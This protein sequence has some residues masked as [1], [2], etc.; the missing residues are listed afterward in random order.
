VTRGQLSKITV[1]AADWAPLTPPSDSFA[2]V[3]PGH[4][5][6][7]FIEPATRHGILSGYSCG[8]PGEPC[9]AQR[10]PYFRPAN[11]ATRGQIAKIIYGAVTAR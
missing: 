1:V 6:Y 2:D 8:G 4:P 5:F 9:D 11:N 3:P 7:T 10:R